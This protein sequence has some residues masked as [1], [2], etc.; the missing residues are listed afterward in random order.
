MVRTMFLMTGV[1]SYI[2]AKGED[3]NELCGTGLE[4][5]IYR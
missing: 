2:Y 1:G 3:Y 4:L 5:Y